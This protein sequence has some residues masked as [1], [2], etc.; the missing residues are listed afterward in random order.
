MKNEYFL[1]LNYTLANEDSN[2]ELELA[3]ITKPQNV[4]A[5][6]G[7]G[8]R[9]LALFASEATKL[10]ILDYSGDQLRLG[11]FRAELIKQLDY[12]SYLKFMGYYPY[13]PIE[14]KSE[15]KKIFENLN[16]DEEI[17]NYFMQ[18]FQLNNWEGLTYHGKWES[19][20][21][22][23][24]KLCR[25][26]IDVEY[27]HKLCSFDKLDDQR[28]FM[29]NTFPYW[30]WKIL[31]ALLGN[32]TV[33]NSLLYKGSFVKKNVNVSHFQYYLNAFSRI[34]NNTLLKNNF[35]IQ[36]CFFGEIIHSNA[37]PPEAMEENYALIKDKLL[38]GCVV[39]WT[40]GDALTE[41]PKDDH[42]SNIDFFSF[43]NVVSYFEGVRE[44]DFLQM[45]S[46]KI[47]KNGIVVVRNYLRLPVDIKMNGYIDVTEKYNYLIG[48]EKTQMYMI[49]VYQK[50]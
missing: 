17:R 25:L 41:I 5:I 35:F 45:I 12:Q 34:F 39:T 7:S 37:L 36:L 9:A 2:F 50:I 46:S 30:K 43:S 4:L 29:Q 47:S 1:S 8:A 10:S 33:F 20:F 27:L 16:L 6:A 44:S 13:K 48:Q 15:R 32:A 18:Y 49:R 28:V 24:S 19:V 3:K 22:K 31:I 42:I 23:F 14:Q 38:A 40:C 26:L 21:K 11:K